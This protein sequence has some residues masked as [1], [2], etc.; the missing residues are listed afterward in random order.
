RSSS[1]SFLS[2]NSRTTTMTKL[3]YGYYMGYMSYWLNDE[4]IPHWEVIYFIYPIHI[5]DKKDHNT[6]G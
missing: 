4:F 5:E 3:L 6:G 2:K 1:F